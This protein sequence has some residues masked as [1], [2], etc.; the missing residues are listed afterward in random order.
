MTHIEAQIQ[1]TLVQYLLDSG[2][3]ELAAACID[4]DI[5]L[6]YDSG[7]VNLDH[8]AINLPPASYN[9]IRGNG[10]LE[11]TLMQSVREVLTGRT[12]FNCDFLLRVKLLVVEEGW[13]DVIRNLIV[14][15]SHPNQGVITEVAFLKRNQQPL[16]YNEMKFGSQSEIRI[17][18]ELE[19]RKVL[20]FPLPLAVRS[21]TGRRYQDHREVDFLVCHNGVWGILEVAYHEHR[22]EKDSEKAGWFKKSGILC[23]EF[24]TAERCYNLPSTVVDEFLD[25]LS[26]HKR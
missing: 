7:G 19:R 1:R 14:N 11:E 24:F 2:F 13:K 12:H 3:K 17:A 5:D 20:F 26:K 6:G 16:L 22:Y 15:S 4:C 18:Q 25:I 10:L 21:E 8:V 23:V 9:F